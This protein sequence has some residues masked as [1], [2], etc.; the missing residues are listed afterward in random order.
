MTRRLSLHIVCTVSGRIIVCS[1]TVAAVHVTAVTSIR[2]VRAFYGILFV[3]MTIGSV[4]E[5]QIERIIKS[6]TY[7]LTHHT[8]C[9]VI[10]F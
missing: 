2:W 3:Q 4:R 5:P 8:A 7:E 6:A 9:D 1:A 10:A